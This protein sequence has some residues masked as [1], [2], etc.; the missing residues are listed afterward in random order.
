MANDIFRARLVAAIGN[1]IREAE[2]ASLHEHFGDRGTIRQIVLERLIRPLLPMSFD[3]G[4]GTIVDALGQKSGQ[5]DIVVYSREIL[6]RILYSERDGVFPV[7]ASLFAIEVKSRLTADEVRD[8]IGKA[9][10]INNLAYMSGRYDEAN[11]NHAVCVFVGPSC[12]WK[13]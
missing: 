3:L 7:E 5:T 6:P 4:T 9:E 12:Q 8:A 13:D 2:N 10:R 11:T 1:A